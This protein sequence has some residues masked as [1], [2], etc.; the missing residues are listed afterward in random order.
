M[1]SGNDKWNW[2]F[3]GEIVHETH[4]F[5]KNI[6]IIIKHLNPCPKLSFRH[7]PFLIPGTEPSISV[8][9]GSWSTSLF[10]PC[11]HQVLCPKLALNS[12]HLFLLHLQ[13]IC[14]CCYCETC[15]CLLLLPLL[16][17]NAGNTMWLA[18]WK[19]CMNCHSNSL[20]FGW[21]EGFLLIGNFWPNFDWEVCLKSTGRPYH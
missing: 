8:L 6:P 14:F 18:C 2:D 20:P 12:H 4:F 3:G 13:C 1:W 15:F 5:L 9:L 7:T 11:S 10:V 19:E 21:H 16:P 17:F